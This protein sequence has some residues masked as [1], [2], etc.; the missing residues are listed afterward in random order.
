MSKPILIA[1]FLSLLLA[2]CNGNAK[3]GICPQPS[4][5]LLLPAKPLSDPGQTPV[6]EQGQLLAQY[7]EDIGKYELLREK[8]GDLQQWVMKYCLGDK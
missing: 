6:K 3:V 5:S 8:H 1:T 7:A 4:P 2:S